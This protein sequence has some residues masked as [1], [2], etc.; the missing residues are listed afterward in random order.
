MQSVYRALRPGGH[1]ILVDMHR[2]EGKSEDWVLNHVRA[3]KEEFVK[4]VVAQGFKKVG[5]EKFLDQSY[6]V[7]FKKLE[8]TA[9]KSK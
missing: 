8:R 5:E 2:I 4:E 9:A 6:F 7:R 1:V 3:S